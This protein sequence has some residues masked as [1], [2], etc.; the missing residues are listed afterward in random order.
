METSRGAVINVLLLD[1][2]AGDMGMFICDNCSSY[3]FKYTF[4]NVYINKVF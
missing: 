3:I 4:L 2:G 1:L